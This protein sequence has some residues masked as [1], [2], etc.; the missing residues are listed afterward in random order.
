MDEKP[1]IARQVVP[2]PLNELL[3]DPSQPRKTFLADEIARLAASIR[4]RGV[5]QPLRVSRDESRQ[6]WVILTGEGR[7][8]A[9]QLAGLETVPCLPVEGELSEIDRLADQLIENSVRHDVPPM[10]EALGLSR[11]KTLEGCTSKALAEKYGFSP[12][13]ITRAEALVSLPPKIRDMVGDGPGQVPPSAAYE[14]S[15]LDDPDAQLKLAHA[16]AGR[17]ITR[18]QVAEAVRSRVGKRNVR[19]KASRLACKLDDGVSLTVS[20]GGPLTWDELFAALDRVRKEAKKLYDG[21]KDV[22]ALSRSLRG[23]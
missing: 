1:G 16:V 3:V 23:L 11:L 12:S 15:R 17:Q 14:I 20:S 6:R 7:Y 22:A 9:A 4:A 2:I 13:A 5:L 10:E 21:G 19:P 8:R 18:D